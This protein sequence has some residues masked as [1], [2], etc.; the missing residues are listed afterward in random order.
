MVVGLCCILSVSGGFAQTGFSS[1]DPSSG[2]YVCV[3]VGHSCGLSRDH[4]GAGLQSDRLPAA[5]HV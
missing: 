5:L 3:R 1:D 4:Y 2:L